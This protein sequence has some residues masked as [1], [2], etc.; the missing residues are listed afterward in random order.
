M[1]AQLQSCK[2][3]TRGWTLQELIAPER[4]TFVDKNWVTLYDRSE[5]QH[6]LHVAV[7][8]ICILLSCCVE[9]SGW[10]TDTSHVI[11]CR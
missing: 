6:T 10:S 7:T 9:K 2:G 5:I 4:M 11:A 1:I 8:A 3:L